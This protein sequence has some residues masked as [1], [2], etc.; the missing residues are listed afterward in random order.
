MADFVDTTQP[1]VL[2]QFANL[3]TGSQNY[4]SKIEQ[5]EAEDGPILAEYFHLWVL[6]NDQG[7]NQTQ[8]D[9]TVAIQQ[10]F[11]GPSVVVMNKTLIDLY[12]PTGSNMN[13]ITKEIRTKGLY[14]APIIAVDL[15]NNP[16]LA[17][18]IIKIGNGDNGETLLY[19]YIA[20]E[21]KNAFKDSSPNYGVQRI[22][23]I[24]NGNVIYDYQPQ[25]LPTFGPPA[26]K[27][28]GTM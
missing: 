4:K 3:I 11:L 6:F 28:L 9:Y 16:A 5:E 12:T 27:N 7:G 10:I 17:N 23:F 21:F 14:Q 1:N 24:Y 26:Y 19:Q 25:N 15:R 20:G 2:E 18:Q 13:T 22:I 8:A